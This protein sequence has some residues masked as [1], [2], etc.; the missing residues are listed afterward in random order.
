MLSTA[1]TKILGK[2]I[3]K[4]FFCY[5][6]I[7]YH[8]HTHTATCF[9]NP[10]KAEPGTLVVLTLPCTERRAVNM[11]TQQSSQSVSDEG[12]W[13]SQALAEPAL[14]NHSL[15]LPQLIW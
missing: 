9:Q 6:I 10:H 3:K 8:I 15:M 4:N 13:T 14:G 5:C 1:A 7:E 2:I 11:D 12:L